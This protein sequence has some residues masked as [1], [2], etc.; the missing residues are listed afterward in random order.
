M[1]Q[2]RVTG[3]Q[4]KINSF[5]FLVAETVNLGLA[6]LILGQLGGFS[7]SSGGVTGQD[8]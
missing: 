1:P 4:I 7:N 5:S 3:S 2:Q 6:A 8:R